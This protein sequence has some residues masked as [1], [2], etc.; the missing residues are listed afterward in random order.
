VRLLLAA[1]SA[2]AVSGCFAALIEL[3]SES[4]FGFACRVL[5]PREAD[6]VIVQVWRGEGVEMDLQRPAAILIDALANATGRSIQDFTYT[7]RHGPDPPRGSWNQTSL[8]AWSLERAPEARGPAILRIVVVDAWLTSGDRLGPGAVVV[9]QAAAMAGAAQT[10]RSP[11]EVAG[12]LFMHYAGHALGV[13]NDGIPVQDPNLQDR[14]GPA[15]HEPD[16]RSV[17]HEGW[18]SAAT[19]AWPPG[20]GP[21]RYSDGVRQDWQAAV[22]GGV[23]A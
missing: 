2:L 15:N 20:A 18:H 8:T 23:C 9:S 7:H 21:L 3:P 11:T 5:D 4:H 10:G 19:M 16:P 22:N 14:E 12:A 1:A 13:V 17:M 6:D